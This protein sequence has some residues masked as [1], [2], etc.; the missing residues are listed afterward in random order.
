M[1]SVRCA[2]SRVYVNAGRAETYCGYAWES[3]PEVCRQVIGVFVAQQAGEL[4][5]LACRRGRGGWL[6]PSLG[7]A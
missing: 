6:P 1:R 3:V 7:E 4:G 5:A 2:V